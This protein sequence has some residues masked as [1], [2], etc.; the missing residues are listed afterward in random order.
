MLNDNG[1]TL[2]EFLVAIVIL[3]VGLLGL[4]QAVNVSLNHNLQNQ[5]RNEGVVVADE[6]MA[7]EMAKG[8]DLVSTSTSSYVISNRPVLNA[9]KNFSVTR[10]GIILQN[11]K[12]VNIAV[13]WHHRGV[14]YNH[15]ASAVITKTNQ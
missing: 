3:M 1:F 6:Q 4:L 5:L 11:S 10:S 8:Y 15:G 14:S 12:Q 13:S 2:I 9:F 7:R